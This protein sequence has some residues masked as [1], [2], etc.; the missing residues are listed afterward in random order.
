MSA[1]KKKRAPKKRSNPRATKLGSRVRDMNNATFAAHAN[2]LIHATFCIN[3]VVHLNKKVRLLLK[4]ARA[5]HL[6][7]EEV[8]N[9]LGVSAGET[10]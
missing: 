6:T 10:R 8:E 2:N 7:L 9:L 4:S 3:G 1:A 5:L